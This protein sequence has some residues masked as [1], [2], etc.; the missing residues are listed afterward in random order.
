WGGTVLAAFALVAR[1]ASAQSDPKRQLS[2]AIGE[3]ARR[4]G[5]T[6]TICRKCYIHPDVIAAHA[7][8]SLTEALTQEPAG[9]DGLPPEE[10]A[11]LRLL[12]TRQR[13]AMSR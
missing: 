13:L 1:E 12:E 2:E 10:R 7:E 5:N 6:V 3:V 11:V 9:N 4:L 8:Q